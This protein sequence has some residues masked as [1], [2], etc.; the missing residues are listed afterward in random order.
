MKNLLSENMLRFGTKNLSESAKQELVVK[1]I[2][3]TINQHGL[4]SVIRKKLAEQAYPEYGKGANALKPISYT[5]KNTH[6]AFQQGASGGSDPNRFAM[7]PKGTVFKVDPNNPNVATG[8]ILVGTKWN[9]GS[10]PAGSVASDIVDPAKQGVIL[11]SATFNK[12]VN[13][14]WSSDWPTSLA[15]QGSA[16]ISYQFGENLKKALQ[17]A[18]NQA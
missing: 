18:F 7:I 1:S 13:V 16:G 8:T 15:V 4:S 3:E 2:M 11:S 12:R 6:G 14:S 17:Q 9:A 10:M 5:V